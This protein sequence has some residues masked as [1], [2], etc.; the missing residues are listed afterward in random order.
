MPADARLVVCIN[1]RLGRG[2]RSCAGS[3]SLALIERIEAMIDEQGI[4]ASVVRRECLGRCEEGPT[5]RIAPGGPFFT[6]IDDAALH[7]IIDRLKLF[8]DSRHGSGN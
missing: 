8:I 7:V 6:E 3:G 2:Q 5:M 4:D 1:R